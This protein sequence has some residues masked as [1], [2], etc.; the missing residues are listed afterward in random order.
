TLVIVM[1][2]QKTIVI[3]KRTPP[4]KHQ[5]AFGKGF[6][7]RTENEFECG[8]RWH[9]LQRQLKLL[10]GQYDGLKF[11]VVYS[12]KS[13]THREERFT[14]LGGPMGLHNARKHGLLRKVPLKPAQRGINEQL[15]TAAIGLCV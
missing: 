7:R 2:N 8:R 10:A 1:G 9:M 3:H 12:F 13:L 14:K 5:L 11:Q 6:A 4:L 15:Q